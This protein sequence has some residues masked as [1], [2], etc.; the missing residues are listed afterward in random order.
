MV[1]SAL[2]FTTVWPCEV[3]CQNDFIT[4]LPFSILTKT[5]PPLLLGIVN[6]TSSPVLYFSLLDVKDNMDA[7]VWSSPPP[8]LC[9]PGSSMYKVEP[10]V[11]P[12]F[13]SFTKIKY[14]PHSFSDVPNV[15][16]P[17]PLV[18]LTVSFFNN[19]L[20]SFCVKLLRLSPLSSHHQ[21]H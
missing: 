8:R 12:L 13:K 2:N 11:C 18:S 20:Y 3:C 19:L 21:R 16:W 6:A 7:A 5:L 1:P 9:Q 4:L 14:R 10:V 17:R 15:Y